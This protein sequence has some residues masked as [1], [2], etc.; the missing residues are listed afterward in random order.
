MATPTSSIDVLTV[1]TMSNKPKLQVNL[2][3]VGVD[4]IIECTP[5]EAGLFR[6]LK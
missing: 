1:D 4:L 6:Y 3:S 5:Q 2:E